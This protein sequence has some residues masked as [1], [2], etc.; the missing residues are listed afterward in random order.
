LFLSFSNANK[1]LLALSPKRNPV[2]EGQKKHD[3]SA[4][5]C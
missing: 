3:L 4:D 2:K 5:T 1:P